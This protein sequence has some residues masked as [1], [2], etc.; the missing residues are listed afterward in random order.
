[1]IVCLMRKPPRIEM[2]ARIKWVENSLMVGQSGS[3]HALVMDGEHVLG[4]HPAG[5]NRDGQGAGIEARGVD[6]G[7]QGIG[8]LLDDPA[9]VGPECRGEIE[10]R[11]PAMIDAVRATGSTA[12]PGVST[13]IPSTL[14]RMPISKSFAMRMAPSGLTSSLT[15]WRIVFGLRAGATVAAV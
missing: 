2:K 9:V 15:F 6:I 11:L 4:G 7:H 3:G 8:A 14:L 10:Q 1:M 5:G 13:S 12:M